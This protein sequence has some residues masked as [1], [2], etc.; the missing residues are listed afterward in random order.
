MTAEEVSAGMDAV[1]MEVLR[2]GGIAGPPV[3]AVRLARTLGVAVAEDDRQPGRGRYV[4]LVGGCRRKPQ[5][6]ILVRPEPRRERSQWT[7]AHEIGEHVAHRLFLRLGVDPA[8]VTPE[9]RES[10]ANQ[11]AGRL[12][13]PGEWFAEDGALLGWDLLLLKRRYATASHEL[14]ARRMLEMPTPLIVTIFDQSRLHFRRSNVP[15]RVPALSPAEQDCWRTAHHSACPHEQFDGLSTIRAWPIHEPGWKREI[16][17]TEV[18]F[19]L[20]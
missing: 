18:Q 1:V 13:L 14:I 2:E 6:A 15:G 10:A 20:V 17:R 5:P 19:E 12:L 3:D 8:E 11:M 4:R 16:L 7:V 9:A